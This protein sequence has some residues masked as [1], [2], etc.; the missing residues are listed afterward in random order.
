MPCWLEAMAMMP[1]RTGYAGCASGE[2]LSTIHRRSGTPGRVSNVA[3]YSTWWN[4]A[5]A[6][7]GLPETHQTAYMRSPFMAVPM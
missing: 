3:P 5:P 6:M 7:L 4:A 2:R 1:A